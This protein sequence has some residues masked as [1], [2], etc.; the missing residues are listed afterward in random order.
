MNCFISILDELKAP[1]LNISGLDDYHL[2]AKY[3]IQGKANVLI[4]APSYI[5]RLLKENE[6]LFKSYGRIKKVFYAGEP[7][8]KGQLEYLQREFNINIIRSMI[9][10]ANETGTMGYA[11][12]FCEPG[13]FHLPTESQYL[14]ILEMDSDNPVISEE[15]GRLIFTGYKRE[16]GRTE[17]YEIGDLG[18]WVKGT[19][20]C[21][22]KQ[23]R[24]KL[25]GRYG[26]VIRLGGTFFNY[27]RINR[28]L[29]DA[30]NYSGRLQI[31]IDAN[32]ND[33]MTFCM[34]NI[35]LT[36]NELI[37]ILLKSDYDSFHKT[38]PTKLVNIKL[39]II[40]PNEFIMNE[41]SLKLRPIIYKN[42]SC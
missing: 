38:I 1:H 9:Y 15:T 25:M 5:V 33:S 31:L 7:M 8:S 18:Q 21:G 17:R 29:S 3:I 2:T 41:V 23:P 42:L 13:V 19:C 34:E 27:Q 4:G 14:E 32:T 36:E 16:N 22:R 40:E 28:I 26:D 12:E 30:L 11:C 37:D 10:G 24:F 20:K 39:R 35:D 6:V